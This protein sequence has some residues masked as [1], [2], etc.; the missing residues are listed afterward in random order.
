[1]AE[2]LAYLNGRF[3]PQAEAQLP[4]HDAG[5]VLG[6]TITDLCRTF[7]HR[8]YRFPDH[9]TRFRQSCRLARLAQPLGDTELGPIAERIVAANTALL[10]AEQDL[11]LVMFATPGP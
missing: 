1:M 10:T 4:L 11:A 3:L 9:L 2:P 6:A 8:L 7:R 5:F